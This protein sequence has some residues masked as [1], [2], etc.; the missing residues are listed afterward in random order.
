MTDCDKTLTYGEQ[1]SID[2]CAGERLCITWAGSHNIHEGSETAPCVTN[3]GYGATPNV[4]T[5]TVHSAGHQASFD[6][7]HAEPGQTRYFFCS[8]HCGD[9]ENAK[10][11]TYCPIVCCKAMTAECLACDAGV[12]VQ[13]YCSNHPTTTGCSESGL[14]LEDTSNVGDTPAPTPAATSAAVCNDA[15][16]GGAIALYVLLSLIHI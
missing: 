3:Y 9:N 15:E 5:G 13:E 10:F 16:R 14:N 11:R 12:S 4:I 7:L 8:L 2:L 6:N 1:E